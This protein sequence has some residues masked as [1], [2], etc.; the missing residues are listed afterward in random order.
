MLSVHPVVEVHRL[1]SIKLSAFSFPFS[2]NNS[3]MKS[4]FYL[5]DSVYNDGLVIEPRSLKILM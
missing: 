2:S 1:E 5:G 3:G 4:D